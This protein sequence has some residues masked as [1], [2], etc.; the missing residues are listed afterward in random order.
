MVLETSYRR[1]FSFIP[2]HVLAAK[3]LACDP[4]PPLTTVNQYDQD[5]FKAVDDLYSPRIR[6]RR[7]RVNDERRLA[8]FI[9]DAA[10]RQQLQVMYIC[11]CLLWKYDI[12][13]VKLLIQAFFEAHPHFAQRFPGGIL[14]FAQMAGQLPPD[15]L[16][17]LMLVEA[18]NPAP[19]PD[20]AMPGGLENVRDDGE[21]V[22]EVNFNQGGPLPPLGAVAH[23]DE[24]QEEDNHDGDEEDEEEEEEEVLSVSRLKS[25]DLRTNV[26]FDI[27]KAYAP[28]DQKY[29]GTIHVL[30]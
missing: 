22:V 3:S 9:P 30:G 2:S 27:L 15:V 16:E 14:Q 20:G 4:L 23:G 19:G 25:R 21:N 5:F 10:F 7:Q 17:D 26:I 13:F 6:S 18:I 1:L 11:T 12:I 24:I 29:F 28:R 8:Q